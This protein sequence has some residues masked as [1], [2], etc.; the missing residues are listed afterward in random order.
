MTKT[1]IGPSEQAIL[2]SLFVADGIEYEVVSSRVLYPG[3][4]EAV[5]KPK[6]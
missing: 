1:F 3:L 4:V 6:E 2:D 5:V